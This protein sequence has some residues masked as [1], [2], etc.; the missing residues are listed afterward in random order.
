MDNIW[1]LNVLELNMEL[2]GVSFL[3]DTRA[4]CKFKAETILFCSVV[5]SHLRTMLR[6]K[7]NE[8]TILSSNHNTGRSKQFLNSAVIDLEGLQC[9]KQEI[10]IYMTS[11]NLFY[12]L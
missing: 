9:C 4:T 5:Y 8:Y 11:L 12:K 6:W 7:F 3:L 1:E 10:T 2:A